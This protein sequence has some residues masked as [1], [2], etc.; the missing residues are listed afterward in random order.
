MEGALLSGLRRPLQ[1]ACL[2]SPAG[3]GGWVGN[4]QAGPCCSQKPGPSQPQADS[5]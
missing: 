4:P 5:N 1:V 3:T 2:H